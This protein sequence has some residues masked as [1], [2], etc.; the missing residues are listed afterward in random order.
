VE[1]NSSGANVD[2]SVA[3]SEWCHGDLLAVSPNQEAV[4]KTQSVTACGG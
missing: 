4:A 1:F 3:L 2:A